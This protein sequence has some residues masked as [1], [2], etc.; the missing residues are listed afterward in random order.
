LNLFQFATTEHFFAE[1]ARLHSHPTDLEIRNGCV[2]AKSTIL[3][4]KQ[5]GPFLGKWASEPI[6]KKFAWE[7]SDKLM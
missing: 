2:F 5:Y 3:K 6:D 7:V 1:M 4:G